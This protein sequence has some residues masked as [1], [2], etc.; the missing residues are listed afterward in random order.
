MPGSKRLALAAAVAVLALCAHVA[1]ASSAPKLPPLAEPPTAKHIPGKFV[2]FDL[3]TPDAPA[4]RAFYASVFGWTYDDIPAAPATYAVARSGGLPI[5]GLYTPAATPAAGAGARWLSFASVADLDRAVAKMIARGARVVTP[6]TRVPDRGT[7]ALL[8]DSQGALVG[9]L[10]S[11]SGDR[12]DEPVAAGEFFWVDL[13]ARDVE[14]AV[15]FYAD[16]GYSIDREDTAGSRVLLVADGHA[17][18]GVLPL[19]PE[20]RE[21]GWLPY[22][23][24]DDVAATVAKVRGAGGRVL[25]EPDAAV[26]DGRLAVIADPHGAVLGLIHWQDEEGAR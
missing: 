16:L 1:P 6:A 7:H 26:L 9:V 12:P 15:Q 10:Q 5:A 20:G 19:P 24:V 8:R 2:W 13:Y 21:S 22:V 4:A 3:V 18:A 11:A 25:R 23:Q 14:A 17:R